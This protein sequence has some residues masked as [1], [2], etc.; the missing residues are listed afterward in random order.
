MAGDAAGVPVD[1]LVRAVYKLEQH[2]ML[3]Q[4]K[5]ANN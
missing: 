2:I 1:M 3:W 4:R 5:S